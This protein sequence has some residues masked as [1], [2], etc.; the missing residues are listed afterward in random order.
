M[1]RADR[2]LPASRAER[3]VYATDPITQRSL[4]LL[5]ERVDGEA[6]CERVIAPAPEWVVHGHG[7]CLI[8]EV[9]FASAFSLVATER[10]D[11]WKNS[12][13]PPNSLFAAW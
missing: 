6:S 2:L 3:P 10:E 4:S 5:P 11:P 1:A 7:E 12:T 13:P 8:I 9:F